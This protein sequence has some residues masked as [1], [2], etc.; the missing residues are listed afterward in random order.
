[1]GKMMARLNG[2][3]CYRHLLKQLVQKDIKLKY[4]RS[5]LGYLWS[6]LNPLLTMAIMVAVFQ[7]F[8]GAIFRIF[9]YI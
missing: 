2:F 5:F 7:I 1:M 3:Y 6:V 4:R 8:L 9:L